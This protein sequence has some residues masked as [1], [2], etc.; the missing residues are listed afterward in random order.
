MSDLECPPLASCGVA[1]G[2][3][4]SSCVDFE[5]VLVLLG[6]TPCKRSAKR[7]IP[8]CVWGMRGTGSLEHVLLTH[9]HHTHSAHERKAAFDCT[10]VDG[11]VETRRATPHHAD[12][13]G[14]Y[15]INSLIHHSCSPHTT[16]RTTRIS[17]SNGCSKRVGGEAMERELRPKHT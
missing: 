15:E 7:E 12:T 3:C 2:M 11:W 10:N 14:H 6:I 5:A 16:T 13:S 9:T 1:V 8:V 17:I 4:C